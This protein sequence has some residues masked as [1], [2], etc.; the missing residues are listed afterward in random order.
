MQSL[1]SKQFSTDFTV[2]CLAKLVFVAMPFLCIE[3]ALCD[4]NG[5]SEKHAIVEFIVE[6]VGNE[7]TSAQIQQLGI[8][9][10]Q[11]DIRHAKA[12]AVCSDVTLGDSSEQ[13]DRRGRLRATLVFSLC[14]GVLLQDAP[15]EIDRWEPT[16]EK[17]LEQAL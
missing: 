7:C 14:R 16:I 6:S 4:E 8:S 12:V 11:C 15:F 9:K 3:S 1:T 17:L 10:S 2:R 5:T 13:L